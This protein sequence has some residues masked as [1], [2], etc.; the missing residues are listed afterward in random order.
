MKSRSRCLVLFRSGERVTPAAWP[1]AR[2]AGMT[3]RWITAGWSS[4]C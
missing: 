3:A 4:L 1:E 2:S